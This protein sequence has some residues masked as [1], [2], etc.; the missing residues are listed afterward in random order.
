MLN[1]W[2]NSQNFAEAGRLPILAHGRSIK[3]SVSVLSF[4]IIAGDYMAVLS[5][6]SQNNY[7]SNLSDRNLTRNPHTPPTTLIYINSFIH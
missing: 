2:G 6:C 1:R 5:F 3:N 7:Q 4:I